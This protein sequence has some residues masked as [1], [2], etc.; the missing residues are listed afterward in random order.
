MV[1]MLSQFL[2]AEWCFKAFHLESF[3]RTLYQSVKFNRG[4]RE[5]TP[6][7]GDGSRPIHRSMYFSS[8]ARVH[9]KSIPPCLRKANDTIVHSSQTIRIVKKRKQR[10]IPPNNICTYTSAI[11]RAHR[12]SPYI[13]V[14]VCISV[15]INYIDAIFRDVRIAIPAI[16]QTRL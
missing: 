3:S 5:C 7:A 13:S 16:T 4:Q 1:A 9:A 6:R 10:K 12:F 8:R 11:A 2:K 15:D 14:Y